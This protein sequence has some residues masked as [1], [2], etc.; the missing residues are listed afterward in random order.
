RRRALRQCRLGAQDL[1]PEYQVECRP[2]GPGT[3]PELFHDEREEDFEVPPDRVQEGLPLPP[4]CEAESLSHDL[5]MDARGLRHQCE[6]FPGA[7]IGRQGWRE[8]GRHR[9]DMDMIRPQTPPVQGQGLAE[10]GLGECRSTR[11]AVNPRQVAQ[12]RS[13]MEIPMLRVVSADPDGL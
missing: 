11:R 2:D 7:T 1:A 4:G 10:E 6:G 5:I 13:Q 9:C 8:G 12:G 3:S